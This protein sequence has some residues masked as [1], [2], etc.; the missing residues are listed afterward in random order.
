MLEIAL[1]NNCSGNT[2]SDDGDGTKNNDR[3][4]DPL[5]GRGLECEQHCNEEEKQRH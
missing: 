3:S 5:G 2:R 4:R 1:T